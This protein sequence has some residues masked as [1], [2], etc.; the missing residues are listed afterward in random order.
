MALADA[1]ASEETVLWDVLEEHLAEA[2]FGIDELQRGLESPVATLQSLLRGLEPRFLAHVDGLALGGAPV[3][4]K[5]LEPIVGTLD[6]AQPAALIVAGFVL[7][8]A[9]APDALLPALAH[10]DDG[11]R[12]AAV[13]AIVLG[14]GQ[15]VDAWIGLK[16]SGSLVPKARASL[17]DVAWRRRVILSPLVMWLQDPDA[18]VVRWAAHSAGHIDPAVH[19]PALEHLLDH[20]DVA[21]R[22]AALV[23]SLAWGSSRAVQ[24]SRQWGLDR[25]TPRSVPMTLLAALEGPAVHEDLAALC[26][27]PTHVRAAITALG[28]CGNVRMLPRLLE[29]VEGK[30][31]LLRKL[32]AQSISLITG[33]KLGEVAA[34]AAT[35]AKPD[36]RGI[37]GEQTDA[38]QALPP[39]EEDDLDADIVPP[40]EDA[41]PDPDPKAVRDHC[42]EAMARLNPDQRWLCGKPFSVGTLVEAL[43]LLPMRAR[44]SI[45][46][47]LF[48]RTAGA[49]WVDT[50]GLPG[51][52]VGRLAGM[53]LARLAPVGRW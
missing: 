23:P 46:T 4:A 24:Y 37:V 38:R 51:E 9:G 6:P 25:Q 5:L 35:P 48:V 52:Q 15:T 32:A 18:L 53:A 7:A 28:H 39:L 1:S 11:I 44:H 13:E 34:G 27:Y 17:L 21:V 3:R 49:S 19:G 31:P 42:G 8:S 30:T 16:L 40:P 10:E 50:R 12:R 20:P 33:M 14:G 22:E 45:A 36:E 2:Q 26:A 43:Q 29:H 41:L 47:V